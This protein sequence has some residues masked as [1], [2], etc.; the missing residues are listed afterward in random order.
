MRLPLYKRCREH[1]RRQGQDEDSEREEGSAQ[2]W[3]VRSRLD[4]GLWVWH[5]LA[6]GEVLQ[7]GRP[8]GMRAGGWVPLRHCPEQDLC[9]SL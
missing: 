2:G 9:C 4:L 6:A 7:G 5:P 3:D 1:G 8:A